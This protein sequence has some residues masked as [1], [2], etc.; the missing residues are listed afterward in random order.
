MKTIEGIL[1]KYSGRSDLITVLE[2]IQEEFGYVSEENMRRVEQA[3]K[4]P[5]VDI[6]G[7]VTFYAAFKLKP[8]GKHVIRVC[9][10]TAC[11][12]KRSDLI[13]AYIKETLGL[14]DNETTEDGVFTLESVN[15]LGACAYAPTM[16]VDNEVFGQLT[17]E[18]VDRVLAKFK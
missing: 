1:A 11:H 14:K 9:S 15:C 17:R 5:L 4:I 16:M 12:V 6:Y 13:H 3:L 18:K 2:E 8:S 10:G 7:V